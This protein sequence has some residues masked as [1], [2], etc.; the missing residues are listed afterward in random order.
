M[1]LHWKGLLLDFH[2]TPEYVFISV[3]DRAMRVEG[4]L[5]AVVV[6]AEIRDVS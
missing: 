5:E 2:S 4:S 6:D 1:H 3:G